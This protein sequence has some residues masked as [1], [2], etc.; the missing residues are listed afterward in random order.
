MT[1]FQ[2]GAGVLWGTP[3][4]NPDGSAPYNPT[5]TKFGILQEVQLDVEFQTKELYGGNQFPYAI[6]RGQGKIT[7]NAKSAQIIGAQWAQLF[8]GKSYV[9]GMAI[10]DYYDNIGQN[11]PGSTLVTTPAAPTGAGSGTGGSIPAGNNFAKIVAVDVNGAFSAAGPE[12]ATAVATTGSASSIAWTWTAVSGAA[13]YRIYV[14]TATG[15]EAN[16][17]TSTTNSFTQTAPATAG[18]PGA[19]PTVGQITIVPPN[20]GTFEADLGVV[21][22]NGNPGQAVASQAAVVA[23][24]QYY[25]NVATGTYYFYSADQG[26]PVYIN[27]Q[28][29]NTAAQVPSSGSFLVTSD[30][31]GYSPIFSVDLMLTYYGK[32]LVLHLFQ[33]TSSKLSMPTKL[34]DFLIPQFDIQAFA[35]SQNRVAQFSFTGG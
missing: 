6:G 15:A 19:V 26:K 5:P 31:M 10:A 16:Y 18:T 29:S 34:D 14:G 33:C 17:F 1:Q 13:S 24:G 2:F 12:N 20:G 8:F 25:C 9:A 3:V 11:I 27:Y 35:D 21:L 30:L 4:L 23:S 32:Q 7:A 28:Y 22:A